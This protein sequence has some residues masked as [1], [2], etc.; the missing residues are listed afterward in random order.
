MY[1][2]GLGWELGFIQPGPDHFNQRKLLRRAIGPQGIGNHNNIIESSVQQ[3]M[4]DLA[5]FQGNPNSVI[6]GYVIVLTIL[7][8]PVLHFLIRN[9]STLGKMVS[10][11]TYGDQIWSMMGGDL[12]RW[13]KAA[14]T[15]IVEAIFKFWLV[16]IF[17]FCEYKEE[18]SK[19]MHHLLP[20]SALRPRL[21]P[22]N[23]LQ[24]REFVFS[25]KSRVNV[26]L[27]DKS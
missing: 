7:Y 6:E 15:I 12:I 20:N 5:T 14:M 2:M 24:V 11:A 22:W 27:S 3:C 26:Y 1:S 16:N 9:N 13:N 21:G 18:I 19:I 23:A 17:H 25:S 8:T 4:A 10:K